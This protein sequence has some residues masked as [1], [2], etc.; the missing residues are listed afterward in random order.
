M[1]VP[2][3]RRKEVGGLE[4][5]L[6]DKLYQD[7]GHERERAGRAMLRML[8]RFLA[9]WIRDQQTPACGPDPTFCLCL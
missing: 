5:D 4:R 8:P 9:E 3:G 7:V 6:G 2:G 1:V